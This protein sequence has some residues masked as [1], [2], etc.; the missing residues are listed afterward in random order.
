M[1]K[2]QTLPIP[3]S[4]EE[5]LLKHIEDAAYRSLIAAMDGEGWHSPSPAH[6]RY[7]QIVE[8]AEELGIEKKLIQYAKDRGERRVRNGE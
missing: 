7:T 8:L 4:M 5:V 2:Q 6:I 1:N 3:T